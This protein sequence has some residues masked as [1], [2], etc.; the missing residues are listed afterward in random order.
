MANPI[1]EEESS[2]LSE[3][4]DFPEQHNPLSAVGFDGDGGDPCFEALMR[5]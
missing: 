5:E 3:V 2:I 4:S 1:V